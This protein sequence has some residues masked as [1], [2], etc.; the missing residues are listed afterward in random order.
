MQT[1]T[2]YGVLLVRHVGDIDNGE[3]LL[4]RAVQFAPS[5]SLQQM[6]RYQ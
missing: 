1:L 3:R 6:L 5:P 2:N 4:D